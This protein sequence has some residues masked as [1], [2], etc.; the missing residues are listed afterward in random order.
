[1]IRFQG[2]GG[3]IVDYDKD[4]GV[5][6]KRQREATQT[7]KYAIHRA[8]SCNYFCARCGTKALRTNGTML[9]EMPARGT[10]GARVVEEG[11]KLAQLMLEPIPGEQ[12]ARVPRPKGVELQYRLGC[13]SCA[14][15]I[16]Y[17]ST[18]TIASGTFLYVLP[19]MVREHPDAKAKELEGQGQLH[20][21]GV[22]ATTT[23]TASGTSATRG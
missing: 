8:A 18:P 12:P 13:R 11:A 7:V 2:H 22:E 16:A 17:R 4:R 14:T 23:P 6:V 5:A 10:D 15:A 1:M 19:G 3:L 20:Q 21:S 9:S